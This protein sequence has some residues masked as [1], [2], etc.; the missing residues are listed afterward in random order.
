MYCYIKEA[1]RPTVVRP[2][3]TM[4]IIICSEDRPCRNLHEFIDWL[5][6]VVRWQKRMTLRAVA[7]EEAVRQPASGATRYAATGALSSSST[8]ATRV[9]VPR[10]ILSPDCCVRWARRRSTQV[11][12]RTNRTLSLPKRADFFAGET[13]R[14]G[15]RGSAA[16][17]ATSRRHHGASAPRPTR[18][19]VHKSAATRGPTAPI[20]PQLH[21]KV[22]R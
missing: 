19:L 12:S 21:G 6:V 17:S 14:R 1:K 7:R 15:V 20:T 5:D 11:R 8:A 3:I 13:G 22:S 16:P 9:D 4:F 2:I 10:S 18:P